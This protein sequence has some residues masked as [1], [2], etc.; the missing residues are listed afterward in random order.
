MASTEM[1]RRLTK[2][3]DEWEA[4][5][6]LAL[7]AE[8]IEE[9]QRL[10]Y[11]RQLDLETPKKRSEAAKDVSG[12]ANAQGGLLIYGVEEEELED[13]RRIPAR[14]TPLA[15]GDV[16]SRLED[17]LDSA[18]HPALNFEARQIDAE[19]GGYFLVVRT[20]PRLGVPHMVDGYGEMRCY[21]RVGLKTRPMEQHELAAAFA[22]AA[23]SESR[24][25]ER[26]TRL[27][28][29][30][31][32]DG[33][34][35]LSPETS[36]EPGPW[37]GVLAL[38]VDAPEPLLPMLEA[39]S[40]AFP[41]DGDYERWSRS[42]EIDLSLRWDADG[43][44][45]DREQDDQ[46]TRRLRLF[47]NG[48]FEWGMSLASWADSI[49]SLSIA[50]YLHDVLGYFAIS[51]RRVGYFGRLRVWV[52]LE[53]GEGSQLGLGSNYLAFDRKPLSTD[54]LEW[55]GD[56][57]VDGLLHDLTGATRAA[58]D[59]VFVAYG[60]ARCFYFSDEGEPSEELAGR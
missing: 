41:D 30:V 51:Y 40:R 8:K 37:L 4:S 12:L 17:V 53:N 45:G 39:D 35:L 19:G 59:R 16:R 38:P 1:T 44:H 31:R 20:F 52:S 26:L 49:P 22:E 23:R 10:E 55:R 54:H 6:V 50:Q 13:G 7:V 46:L 25:A 5:D 2:P 3:L 43:Y 57:S 29:I 47:R 36:R 42:Q 32:P 60:L 56:Y 33:V 27:P 34:E 21:V 48:V 11:K 9:G 58:M 24:A 28:L 15:D 18:V 14:S